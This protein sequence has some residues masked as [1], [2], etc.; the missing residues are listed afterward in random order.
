ML[1]GKRTFVSGLGNSLQWRIFSVHR[2]VPH[3]NR[4]LRNFNMHLNL[5]QRP[6]RSRLS[7]YPLS[8]FSGESKELYKRSSSRTPS[9]DR[10]PSRPLRK[11][12]TSVPIPPIPPSTNPRGELIFSSRVDRSFRES[13]ERYRAAFERMREERE[14]HAAA[15]TW[16]GMRLWPWNWH[17]RN[18]DMGPDAAYLRGGSPA[19][20]AVSKGGGTGTDNT[21][22]PSRRPSPARMAAGKARGSG[23]GSRN[24][25][26]TPTRSPID[27]L[28]T[29]GSVST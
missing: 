20:S 12:G 15:R 1:T 7:L 14:R 27:R 24:A 6:L 28:R 10:V 5:R 13:Y 2:Y 11:R 25:S 8:L 17:W 26:L 21:P 19:N 22:L 9:P 4:A 18:E 23:R 16:Y 29:E 3:A